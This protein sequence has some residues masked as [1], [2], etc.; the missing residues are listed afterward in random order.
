MHQHVEA[1]LL[2]PADRRFRFLLQERLV[3]LVAE[4]A[5][6][7][8]GT[9]LA[10]VARLREGADR[11]RREERQTDRRRLDLAAR[12]KCA[13]ARLHALV[14]AGD[15]ALDERV[16]H[17]QRGG[18]GG[19]GPRCTID[20][21]PHRVLP[22]GEPPADRRKLA[23]LLRGKGKPGLEVRIE[24]RFQFEVDR[25]M[26]Q[27]ARGG[28]LDRTGAARGN[29]RRQPAKDHRK[30][31][32]PDVAPVD[33]AERQDPIGPYR[34]C[35]GFELLRRSHQIDVETGDGER[36]DRFQIAGQRAEIGRQH[37]LQAR[38][39]PG[40]RLIGELEGMALAFRQVER[41]DGFVNLHPV[42]AGGLQPAEE[43]LVD[44][45][46][47]C[48]EIE[49][50]EGRRPG[51]R[52]LEEGHRT[53]HD[54]PR[55]NAER[56]GLQEMIDRLLRGEREGLILADLGD[57]VVIVRV[58]PLG[59]FERRHALRVVRMAAVGAAVAL[60]AAR[61]R[62]VDRQRHLAARPAVGGRD[63]ADHH[64]GVEYMVVEGEIVG[65][66]L[67]DALVALERPVFGAQPAGRFE[68]VAFGDPAGPVAFESEFQLAVATDAREAEGGDRESLLGH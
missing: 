30:V 2:L 25:H 44:R 29:D 10:D 1:D 7:M 24:R 63:R 18:A 52:E 50:L 58:E 55:M 64:G 34:L 57:H 13:A 3:V 11:R 56:P 48:Q 37:H 8:G 15:A 66:N 28:D 41:Q 60:T 32:L 12:F 14:D 68:K 49:R 46:Q 31:R 42:G 51:L 35:D 6:G 65:G 67:R 20:S 39:G 26:Q 16:G 62:E 9:G 61:H 59:H 21:L 33:D 17:L 43:L 22:F 4:R 53:E 19:D 23:Q 45:Q 38:R 54:R 40:K 36:G 5:L 27:G 47:P